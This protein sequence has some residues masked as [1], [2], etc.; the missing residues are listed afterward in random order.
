MFASVAPYVMWACI[1]MAE[2]GRGRLRRTDIVKRLAVFTI[3]LSGAYPYP[4]FIALAI[5]LFWGLT[6]LKTLSKR[7][8]IW[9]LLGFTAALALFYVGSW[10]YFSLFRQ[11]AVDFYRTWGTVFTFIGLFQFWGLWPSFLASASPTVLMNLI[12]NE[13][14]LSG[15]YFI[16]LLLSGLTLY[17]LY[18]LLKR[19]ELFFAAFALMFVTTIPLFWFSLHDSY[20]LYKFLYLT[21]F[22]AITLMLFGAREI[23][24]RHRSVL[25]KTAVT[26]L[27]AIWAI[28]NAGNNLWATTTVRHLSFNKQTNEYRDVISQF[29]AGDSI[30]ID[31]PRRGTRGAHLSIDEY[32]VRNY[33]TD[34]RITYTADPRAAQYF[35]RMNSQPEAVLPTKEEVVW[36]NNVFRLIKAPQSDVL[37]VGS[38]WA[39]ETT[40]GRDL[41]PFRWV[42]D[43]TN[44]W[45]S[46]DIIRRAPESRFL[47]FCV[48][49]GPGVDYRPIPITV[50]DKDNVE[51]MVETADSF[52]CYWADI[53]G[54]R[55]PVTIT[56]PAKGKAV[57]LIEARHL[58][59]RISNIGLFSA[60]HTLDA[61]RALNI[62][63]D[64]TPQATALALETLKLSNSGNVFLL[65]GWYGVENPG[66]QMFRWARN[67][68]SV[69]LESATPG[70]LSMELEPGPSLGTAN[71]EFTIRIEGG[72]AMQVV[73]SNS[74]SVFDV[75]VTPDK[76]GRSIIRLEV[77]SAKRP[78]PNDWRQLDFR[79]FKIDWKTAKA[80]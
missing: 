22:A 51:L 39:P 58:N 17:G 75:P 40:A 29:K 27:L 31:L 57:S 10:D 76:T 9:V 72:A 25:L 32:V 41:Q 15:S 62:E 48:E 14:L 5:L 45:V 46:I 8:R 42:D 56:S 52:S 43:Q 63:H 37:L 66:S 59:F 11:R 55:L 3:F 69:L 60:K 7:R 19:G 50:T 13:V 49:P 44:N 2:P 47:F 23:F 36:H 38:F 78:V 79:V 65:N 71:P 73:K 35:L 4:F 70:T 77:N 18:R 21:N 28:C 30:Y 53:A 67:G 6:Y 61:L 16:V 20:Y 64:I 80:D 68:A 54:G 12:Q 1:R 74:R 34:A 24:I 26:A 33:L